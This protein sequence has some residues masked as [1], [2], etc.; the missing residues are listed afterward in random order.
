MD[1]VPMQVF[2]FLASSDLHYESSSDTLHNLLKNL[3]KG[4][5]LVSAYRYRYL[6]RPFDKM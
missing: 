5:R 3:L 2:S 1:S 6:K 4:L